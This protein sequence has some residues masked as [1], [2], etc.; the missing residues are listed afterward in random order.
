M[1]AAPSTVARAVR[2]VAVYVTPWNASVM[3]RSRAEAAASLLMLGMSACHRNDAPAAPA[4]AMSSAVASAV[5]SAVPVPTFSRA[6]YRC[7]VFI[8]P[9]SADEHRQLVERFRE[10]NGAEWRG[11]FDRRP[12]PEINALSR[13]VSGAS[14]GELPSRLGRTLEPQDDERV[15]EFLRRNAEFLRITDAEVGKLKIKQFGV[16]AQGR[17]LR[18]Y[19]VQGSFPRRGYEKFPS[20]ERDVHLN[21]QLAEDDSVS[22]Y[23]DLSRRLPPFEIC[24]EPRLKPEAPELH[25]ELIGREFTFSSRRGQRHSSGPIALDDLRTP[26]LTLFVTETQGKQ[27]VITLAYVMRVHLRGGSWDVFVDAD[28]GQFLG[29]KQLFVT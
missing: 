25:R 2:S 18:S 10:L 4:D 20:V 22:S 26:D 9:A 11:L 7:S 12:D 14:R 17:H 13:F 3:L 21:I 5:A 1:N 6:G 23:Q 16:D 28:E 8:P 24:T 27:I 19:T 29:Y 15:R